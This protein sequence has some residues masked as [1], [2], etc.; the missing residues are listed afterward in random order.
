MDAGLLE[1]RSTRVSGDGCPAADGNFA[2]GQVPLKLRRK[3]FPFIGK[4]L[5]KTCLW[6]NDCL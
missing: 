3:P 1:S 6:W 2:T 5:S 4:G